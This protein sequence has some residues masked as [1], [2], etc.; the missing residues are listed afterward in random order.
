MVTP[1]PPPITNAMEMAL[2]LTGPV[3][4]TEIS[5][6]AGLVKLRFTTSQ[7]W[8]TSR[9]VSVCSCACAINVVLLLLWMMRHTTSNLIYNVTSTDASQMRDVVY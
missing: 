1:S 6:R 2:S 4:G 5:A 9:L 8:V 7:F 3:T